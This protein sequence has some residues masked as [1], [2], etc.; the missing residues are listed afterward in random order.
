MEWLQTASIIGTVITAAAYLHVQMKNDMK[1]MRAALS[2]QGA[3]TDKL[4]EM[5]VALVK[6]G[7]K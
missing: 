7:R 2:T 6:E 5:F 4:Y 1:E 3:R